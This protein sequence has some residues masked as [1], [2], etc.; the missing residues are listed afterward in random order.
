M[1]RFSR[2]LSRPRRRRSIR[3]KLLGNVTSTFTR[4]LRQTFAQLFSGASAGASTPD[5]SSF[6]TGANANGFGGGRLSFAEQGV[7]TLFAAGLNVLKAGREKRTTVVGESARSQELQQQFNLS[8][9][10]QAALLAETSQ[11]GG[12]NL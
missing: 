7:D 1:P 4:A 8:R 12:R 11:R 6:F 3:R 9:S 10:Q 5:I 2:S